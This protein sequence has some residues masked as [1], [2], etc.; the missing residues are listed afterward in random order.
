MKHLVT[1]MLLSVFFACAFAACGKK[2]PPEVPA[3]Q[4][5]TLDRKYPNQE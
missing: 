4:T 3:G 1:A 5:D 2:G